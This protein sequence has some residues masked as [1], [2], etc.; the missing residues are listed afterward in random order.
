METTIA[1]LSNQINGLLKKNQ[2]IEATLLLQNNESC[3]WNIN[4]GIITKVKQ[5]EGSV[6]R[7]VNNENEI[8][9]GYSIGNENSFEQAYH[10]AN[11]SAQKIKLNQFLLTRDILD[12]PNTVST[13]PD[14]NNI[15]QKILDKV[16]FLNPI[17]ASISW[18]KEKRN[19]TNSFNVEGITEYGYYTCVIN[20][21]DN[22]YKTYI[23]TDLDNFLLEIENSKTEI[24]QVSTVSANKSAFTGPVIFEPLPFSII[25][26]YL[27]S[28]FCIQ[29]GLTGK[30]EEKLHQKIAPDF[31]TLEENPYYEHPFPIPAF[32]IE[33]IKPQK[34]ALIKEGVLQSFLIDQQAAKERGY[35]STGN[36]QLSNIKTPSKVS[37]N[38]LVLS[39]GEKS[40]DSLIKEIQRGFI[41]KEIQQLSSGFDFYTG[42]FN[43]LVEGNPIENG[44]II[45]VKAK[46]IIRG[47]IL[48]LLND[49]CN[50][51]D[52]TKEITFFG[53]VVCPSVMVDG[54][55]VGGYQL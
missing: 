21:S 19:Y 16:S 9:S 25:L 48:S 51:G 23:G 11:L 17:S 13:K 36:K 33:G 47:N 52:D 54:I 30:L 42:N 55:N 12:A 14:L 29:D 7:I 38:I 8:G 28:W 40:K 18:N 5:F 20:S 26:S 44:E 10:L 22:Q 53:R 2:Q 45:K 34:V 31:L 15:I 27:G 4:Q 6:V 1:N 37:P 39:S 3:I 32:D 43:L 24:H 49:I 46:T 50:V 35:T 41:I